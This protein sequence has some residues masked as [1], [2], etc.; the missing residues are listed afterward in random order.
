MENINGVSTNASDN[1]RL[2]KLKETIDKLEADMVLHTEH[3]VNFKHKDNMN[4]CQQMFQGGK[5]CM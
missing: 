3:T 2:D 1:E 5:A 4:G